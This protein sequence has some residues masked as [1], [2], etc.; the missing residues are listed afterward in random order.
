MGDNSDMMELLMRTP[1]IFLTTKHAIYP[2]IT[3]DNFTRK[4][5]RKGTVFA[6]NL[7]AESNESYTA[8]ILA[9]NPCNQG[10]NNPNY[11]TR[12]PGMP[13]TERVSF[14]RLESNLNVN[15]LV[16]KP[17]DRQK[18]RLRKTLKLETS[19]D[20]RVGLKKIYVVKSTGSSP[21]KFQVEKDENGREY[22]LKD[23][24]RFSN[25][26][27]LPVGAPVFNCNKKFLRK[28]VKKLSGMVTS[29]GADGTLS[30]LEFTADCIKEI[31]NGK[32]TVC[33]V[34]RVC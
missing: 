27:V 30:V 9:I 6:A 14:R 20:D 13:N 22:R 17:T 18:S 32:G 12:L 16:C 11:F 8:L 19:A 29:V 23:T 33:I 31:I 4:E 34:F 21:K 5:V 26:N 15:L 25:N 3:S 7:S 1:K 28:S 2:L 10:D 24:E